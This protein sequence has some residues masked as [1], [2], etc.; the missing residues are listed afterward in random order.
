MPEMF[1]SLGSS[2]KLK[3]HKLRQTM[4]EEFRNQLKDLKNI[5]NE[6]KKL[7]LL[8]QQEIN[9]IKNETER[10]L[11][12]LNDEMSNV[13]ERLE[14][15]LTTLELRCRFYEKPHEFGKER[16]LRLCVNEKINEIKGLKE[17]FENNK[18]ELLDCLLDGESKISKLLTDLKYEKHGGLHDIAMLE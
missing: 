7:G 8:R 10:E 17:E 11:S 13:L 14:V 15:N 1:R 3:E 4:I 16:E 9:E 5:L 2:N 12:M 18:E 6:I